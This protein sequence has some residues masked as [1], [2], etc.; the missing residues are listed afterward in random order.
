MCQEP[1]VLNRLFAF[2]G[3]SYSRP[4]F[5]GCSTVQRTAAKPHGLVL[6]GAINICSPCRA[7]RSNAAS[8]L[9]ALQVNRS[10]ER[11]TLPLPS[12]PGLY[13]Y[14]TTVYIIRILLRTK[15]IWILP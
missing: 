2:L 15:S 13:F 6:I 1:V 9:L 5:S 4:I 10:T 8:G 3:W 11:T 12:Q 7:N 14:F